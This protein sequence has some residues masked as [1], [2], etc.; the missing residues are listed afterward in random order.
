MT[1][2]VKTEEIKDEAQVSEEE[3]KVSAKEPECQDMTTLHERTI[4]AMSYFGFLAIVPFYLKKDSEYCRF[5]GKQG[6]LLAIVFFLAKLFTVIDL[7]FDLMLIL[8]VILMF[9]MGFAALS[10]RWR[11]LPVG[12]KWACQLEE[13]LTLKTKEEEENEVG[14]KPNQVND[15]EESQEKK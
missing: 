12:Y 8:Q 9:M 4:A 13:A 1:D 10:G 7:I 2:E 3:K 6:M 11:K 5:H 15:S 14:L